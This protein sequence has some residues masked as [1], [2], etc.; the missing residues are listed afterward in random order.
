MI[1]RLLT[2]LGLALGLVA[3]VALPAT[4]GSYA[5]TWHSCQHS[6]A[7][8]GSGQA[9]TSAQTWKY[10]YVI[11]VRVVS[12]SPAGSTVTQAW[13]TSASSEK[14]NIYANPIPGNVPIK[15]HHRISDGVGYT[16]YHTCW[17]GIPQC[18]SGLA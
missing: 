9:M 4:A 10:C 15:S 3:V 2:S 17:P 14:R 11:G 8:F 6:V 13:T 7:Q 1:R 12:R 5:H 18:V 16:E